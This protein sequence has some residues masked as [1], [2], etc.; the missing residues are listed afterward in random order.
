[1]DILSCNTSSHFPCWE[2]TPESDIW[3]AI[4]ESTLAQVTWYNQWVPDRCLQSFSNLPYTLEEG[5][6]TLQQQWIPCPAT[7]HPIFYAEGGPQIWHFM[8]NLRVNLGRNCTV[9]PI[10]DWQ[11]LPE[12]PLI[13]LIHQRNDLEHFWTNGCFP[14]QWIILF[15][16][17]R[18]YP[19][20]DIL[21]A[22][23]EST[24]AET[25][26]CETEVADRFFQKLLSSILYIKGRIW[27][28]SEAMN[29]FSCNTSSYF[30]CWGGIPNLTFC[31]Q[32]EIQ[33]WLKLHKTSHK[34]LTGAFRSSSHL[35]HTS[36]EGY[37]ALQHQWMSYLAMHH[38]IFLA[39][40]ES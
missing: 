39:D 15:C 34:W 14:L 1:M 20:S 24:L 2:G 33:C 10:R 16:V 9:L 35:P 23:W 37:G 17:L 31:V 36:K 38:P 6:E 22:I 40:N 7:H 11:M 27:N 25:T 29:V 13:Y 8:C 21:C 32:S 3:R 30:S 5:Y 18:Q 26:Q 12:A 19:K 28:T 4:W